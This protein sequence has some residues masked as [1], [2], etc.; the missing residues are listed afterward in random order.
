MEANID[1]AAP[2][3]GENGNWFRWNVAQRAYEDTGS[4]ARGE[5]GEQG[6]QGPQG[7]EGEQG[8]TG[9]QGPRGVP[10]RGKKGTGANRGPRVPKVTPGTRSTW[11]GAIQALQSWRLLIR[12]GMAATPI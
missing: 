8:E 3:I 12:K 11:R 9:P 2:Y 6:E 10:F 7:P 5:K 1:N 4:P